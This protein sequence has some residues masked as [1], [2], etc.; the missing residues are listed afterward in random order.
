MKK[1]SALTILMIISLASILALSQSVHPA[2]ALYQVVQIAINADGSVT[3]SSTPIVNVNNTFYT[4]TDDVNIT[5]AVAFIIMRSNI[6]FNGNG[7][8]LSHTLTNGAGEYCFSVGD[9]YNN[10]TIANSTVIGFNCCLYLEADNST[11]KGNSFSGTGYIDTVRLK[12]ANNNYFEGNKIT[13]NGGSCVNMYYWPT[14]NNTFV[15]NYIVNS[16]GTAITWNL[17][18]GGAK[19]YHNTI[20]GGI[21]GPYTPACTWD[22]G[23]PSGGN[24]WIGYVSNDTFKG[25]YQNITGSDGIADTPY[26]IDADDIDHYPLMNQLIVPEF[27]SVG[28]LA[29]LMLSSVAVVCTLRWRK[30]KMMMRH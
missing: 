6:V 8:T 26:T 10:V 7:H 30:L 22:N 13:N 29:V 24:Y 27:S 21:I 2:K 9:A 28:V 14:L 16:G 15:E 23:Y 1:K 4:L 11:I 17:G 5:G 12:Y 25:P 3:P 20:G 19:F 18:G